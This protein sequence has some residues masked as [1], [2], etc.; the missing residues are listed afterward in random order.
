VLACCAAAAATVQGEELGLWLQLRL[1]G[2]VLY[3]A[4]S[5]LVLVVVMVVVVVV[6]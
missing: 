3:I 6:V 5:V 4:S 2:W 1:V